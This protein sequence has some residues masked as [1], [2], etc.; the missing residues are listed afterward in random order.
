MAQAPT[1][2]SRRRAIYALV[3][4]STIP[5][6]KYPGWL[7]RACAGE[8]CYRSDYAYKSFR[9]PP[10]L[11]AS[12]AML[13]RSCFARERRGREFCFQLFLKDGEVQ[14]GLH[15]DHRAPSSQRRHQEQA[16]SRPP[17][18][19]RQHPHRCCEHRSLAKKRRLVAA[20]TMLRRSRALGQ[21]R[22][23]RSNSSRM[24]KAAMDTAVTVTARAKRML[25]MPVRTQMLIVLAGLQR[26]LPLSLPHL[27]WRS[28]RLAARLPSIIKQWLSFAWE[29]SLALWG[30]WLMRRGVALQRSSLHACAILASTLTPDAKT[31]PWL[32][33]SRCD[34]GSAW[35]C[36]RFP[37]IG[38][39]AHCTDAT[40]SQVR[41]QLIPGSVRS[42]PSLCESQT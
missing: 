35:L 25:E 23:Q 41:F 40:A 34:Y 10:L 29:T 32:M 22:H 7:S 12:M 5:K 6:T 9:C 24:M 30:T 28:L 27:L 14:V 1:Q 17:C 20:V 16:D 42:T 38:R 31:S 19:A 4:R 26:W 2:P 21:S 11:A 15:P 39:G 13:A 36:V 37:S 8:F 33:L 3:D 18:Q